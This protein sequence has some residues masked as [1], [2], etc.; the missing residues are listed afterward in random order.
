MCVCVCHI[1]HTHAISHTLF[2]LQDKPKHRKQTKGK[3]K[4]KLDMYKIL[5]KKPLEAPEKR[6]R[7]RLEAHRAL[8]APQAAGDMFDELLKPYKG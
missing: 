5:W 8:M 2:C 6:L 4:S 3:G 7:R 1:L